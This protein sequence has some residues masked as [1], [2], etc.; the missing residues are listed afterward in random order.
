MGVLQF[1]VAGLLA[2]AAT[3]HAE[4][5][6]IVGADVLTMTSAQPL[7]DQVV[8][9][10][11]DT[12]Q[13]VGPRSA[14]AVPPGYR[15]VDASGKVVMPGLVDMHV[16]VVNE[17]GRPGDAAQRAL[18]VMLAHG[19]TTARSM[20]G[21]PN[22]IVLREGIEQ[23]R[24]AGPRLYAGSP[25]IAMPQ[26]PSP[27]AAREAVARAHRAGFDFIK[28]HHVP[29]V[30][31]WQAVQDEAKRQ[32]L[33]VAG[34]VTNE[35]GL[36]RAL[37]A[38]QQ[39]EHL[40]GAIAELL[41]PAERGGFEQIPPPELL[42][43]VAALPDAAYASLARK[44]AA[45]G[46][47]QTPTLA[48][49]ERLADT[50]TPTEQLL[51]APE[52]RWIFP[53]A[54][55]AWAAQREQFAQSGF[56][57]QDSGRLRDVRRRIVRAYAQAGVP[58]MAGSDTAQSFMVWG[59]GLIEEI[60]A[61][62]ASGLG[63]YGALRAATVVPRDW[64]RSLPNGGSALGWKANFGTVEPGAR[65]DLVVLDGSPI[66]DLGVLRKPAAVIAAGHV[67]TRADLES[68]LARA[69][70][71]AQRGPPVGCA[72]G[73]PP[74]ARCGTLDVPENRA[75]PAGRRIAIRYAV[76]PA[77]R[78][79]ATQP[80]LVVLP[81]GPGLG[82][83]QQAG[84]VA[85]LFAEANATR[86]LLVIDQRGTGASNPLNCP[87]PPAEALGSLE[88]PAPEEI[89]RCR[90]ALAARADLRFYGTREAV[91]DMEA[92]RAHLGYEKL[93]L[94][95]ISYGTRVALD[96]LR[97]FPERVAHTVIRS[98]APTAMKLPLWSPRDT[99]HAFD[100][101]AAT[102]REQ[103][104]CRERHPDLHADMARILLRLAGGPVDVTFTDPRTKS[105]I[106]T[107]MGRNEFGMLM[108]FLL[109]V[110]E[111]YTQLPP[112]LE[113]AAA[114]DFAPLAQAAA[115]FFMGIDDQLADGLNRT[116]LCSE[117][118]AQIDASEIEAA[119]RG[120]FMGRDVVDR[121]RAA[122][123]T[124]PKLAMPRAYLEPVRSDAPVLIIS[125]NMD[126]VAG[127]P[128]GDEIARTLPK[129]R[130]VVVSGAS[131]LPPL[132]G[133]TGALMQRFIDGEPL[134][135]MDLSCAASRRM[136]PLKP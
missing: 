17:P 85:P 14:L 71:D 107:K 79:K 22:H 57:A 7:R 41:P 4:D 72:P 37:A 108:F 26:V 69:A 49:F 121:E 67:H 59:A 134:A 31:V 111:L 34:H 20:M 74:G 80:P 60:Q 120:T 101:L 46:V 6:A 36:D 91:L 16:H 76:I 83:V 78:G 86:D 19:V 130:R 133:C 2:L 48:I 132:P 125:G 62:A 118:T 90:D 50:T 55:R 21:A 95:A 11:D 33:G 10:H 70:S 82:G 61:L 81:G 89:A 84:G 88:P 38:R 110:P 99:Q 112:L 122:C 97:L 35:V 117:D 129:S 25:P 53:G 30:A 51:A 64:L 58:I 8:L 109:Y 135:S 115:P 136:P 44:V 105:R 124:W 75:E 32:R 94:F 92:I 77:L 93:D 68:M 39:V 29:D 12:I 13:A 5:I 66:A 116:V 42:A 103:P 113:Q 96:Y 9:V 65:A 127:P 114:G 119:T 40:D 63:P 1:V 106:D 52:M 131:H 18:A 87:R 126:P 56:T 128:W 43:K 123:A 28:S 102:C 73:V 23:G 54:L 3:A 47:Y 45:S 27:E 24:V 104:Q 15:I 98:A 100:V